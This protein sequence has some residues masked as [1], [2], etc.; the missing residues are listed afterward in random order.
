MTL[1]EKN[2]IRLYREGYPA[3]NI[4]RAVGE[5]RSYVGFVLDCYFGW[6]RPE[7]VSRDLAT[8]VRPK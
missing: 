6:T 2:I 1:L 3:T 5:D 7:T 4:A 8:A